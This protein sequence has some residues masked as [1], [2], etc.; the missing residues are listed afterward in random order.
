[1]STAD[2]DVRGVSDGTE[3]RTVGKGDESKVGQTRM[4]RRQPTIRDLLRH[5]AGMTYGIFGNTEVDQLY[6]AQRLMGRH[7]NLKQFVAELG[8]LPLQYEPGTRWHYSVAVDVQGRLVEVI[9]GMTFG[10][11]LE[12]RI[13]NPLKMHDT[14]FMVPEDKQERFAQLYSPE[15]SGEGDGIW[16]TRTASRNLV[17]AHPALS[18]RYLEGGQFESGG[19]GLV[20]TADDYLRF[21][22]MLLNGGELDGA[23]L[24]S[25]K[26]VEL[27]TSDH[28]GD[29][30]M[31]WRRRGMGFGLGFGVSTDQAQI[32]ELG[33][34]GEYNWGGAAGTRF[35]VDPQ[36]Q[37]IG[38][39]MVQSLPHR[40]RLGRE[41]KVLTYQALVE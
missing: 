13:F 8:Q 39:F 30:P 17:L 32:G 20:S 12:A 33:S 23:R 10:E 16:R 25:P 3:S 41:F 7:T 15:G 9:S 28:L 31:G 34:T 4:P 19:G 6:R 35:W 37:L 1:M 29:I 24:L 21:A 2:A 22:Q 5:T 27:M 11:F 14:G 18:R 36:E 38:V 40:T 26:T